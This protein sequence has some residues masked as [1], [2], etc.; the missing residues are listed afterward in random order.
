MRRS[1]CQTAPATDRAYAR[2][3]HAENILDM[4]RTAVTLLLTP[5][6]LDRL[7]PYQQRHAITSVPEA[8]LT[9]LHEH[10]GLEEQPTVPFSPSPSIYDGVEDGP[11]EVLSEYL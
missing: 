11:C 5:E 1:G 7:R 9:I 8:I 6:L 2:K 10:L 3:I 4:S